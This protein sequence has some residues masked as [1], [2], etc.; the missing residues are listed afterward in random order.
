MGGPASIV[1][2]DDSPPSDG[3]AAL[4]T[5]LH[6]RLNQLE[7]RYS[8]FQA[9]S[10]VNLINR[11][12]GSGV[13]TEVDRETASLLHFAAELWRAS[14]GLFDITSGVLRKAW[15]FR[16][17]GSASPARL[18]EYLSKVGWELVEYENDAIHLPFAG[19]E[20]DLGG[21]VKEY[22]ADCIGALI[23]EAGGLSA[24]VELAG[25][26]VAIGNQGN[27]QPWQVG[28]RD[29][30]GGDALLTL[31]LCDVAVATSGNYARTIEHAGRKLGHFLNP[32]TGWPVDGPISV[33]ALDRQCLT[34]GAITTVAC[35]KTD[36]Q[37][38]R[39]L[40]DA[41]LPWLMMKSCGNLSGPLL[42][43]TS[44]Q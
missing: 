41:D 36:N 11:R 14:E 39:W 34:A 33:S 5:S 10:V 18:A 1:I 15:D 12:A 42:E 8:R 19:M 25:D 3:H 24:L 22:A 16:S 43:T 13:V 37:A 28:I 26:V 20:I 29:P 23:R 30:D 31:S 7:S 6:S 4:F 21:L 35:L 32:A 27:G 44:H 2:D 9:G 40:E 38:E 17:G